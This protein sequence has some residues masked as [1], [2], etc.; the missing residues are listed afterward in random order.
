V[1]PRVGISACLLGH[2]VRYDGGHKRA[3]YLGGR[4]GRLVEWV[5]VCPEVEL[6]LGVPREPIR[7]VG[8][9]AAPRLVAA[10]SDR[11]LTDAM[12]RFARARVAELVDRELSGYVVKARSPSC[13]MEAV[14]VHRAA[15][16]PVDR[17]RGLFTRVL[18]EQ[19]PLLPVEEEG[20]LRSH[21]RRENFL[22]RVLAYQHWRAFVAER[23][24][25]TRLEAFHAAHE[26]QLLAH[27]RAGHAVLDRLVT[28]S[29]RRP[30][31]A[32]LRDYGAG[33]MRVL[34]GN[35]PCGTRGTKK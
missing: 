34:T 23:P 1:K 6:G 9:I 17:G 29:R 3:P 19:M 35:V 14:P 13:G 16:R 28:R 10:E 25:R 5:P 32:V 21:A 20:A 22:E 11:D 30:L 7:L 31:A 15:G 26:R 8:R 33:F 4:L 24:T 18:I 27:D 12:L 2:Q